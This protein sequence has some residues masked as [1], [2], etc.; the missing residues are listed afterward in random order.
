MTIKMLPLT[1]VIKQK[2][3]ARYLKRNI[4]RD[5]FL[6]R[7]FM[8]YLNRLKTEKKGIED[9]LDLLSN[10]SLGEEGRYLTGKEEFKL[11]LIESSM[12]EIESYLVHLD[13]HLLELLYQAIFFGRDFKIL[14]SAGYKIEINHR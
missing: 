8:D 12:K 11:A 10:F 1:F 13:E 2:V 6:I 4:K 14:N 3:H 5:G 9:F 7:R